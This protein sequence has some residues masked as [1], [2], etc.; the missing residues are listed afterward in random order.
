MACYCCSLCTETKRK[1]RS[2]RMDFDWFC[3]SI[4]HQI[5]PN[6]IPDAVPTWTSKFC[7]LVV[8][9]LPIA[10]PIWPTLSWLP[11][12]KQ[13]WCLLILQ[14]PWFTPPASTSPPSSLPASLS[15]PLASRVDPYSS[16]GTKLGNKFGQKGQAQRD[17]AASHGHSDTDQTDHLVQEKRHIII[18]SHTHRVCI[19]WIPNRLEI[20]QK[21]IPP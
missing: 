1:I 2:T 20:L 9:G 18:P 12:P 16:E 8:R 7:L 19:P 13:P 14:C 15:S 21:K 5:A 11:Y 6:M 3:V 10:G 4:L 17:P